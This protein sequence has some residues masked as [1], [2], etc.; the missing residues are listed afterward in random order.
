[1]IDA[2]FPSAPPTP[3]VALQLGPLLDDSASR[4]IGA[5]LMLLAC[6]VIGMLLLRW[7]RPVSWRFRFYLCAIILAQGVLLIRLPVDL[8]ILPGSFH[9]PGAANLS[10]D[11]SSRDAS[12]QWPFTSDGAHAARSID[13]PSR[14]ENSRRESFDQTQTGTG[15][16]GME[17]FGANPMPN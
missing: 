2:A 11:F 8:P 7:L 4:F 13:Q 1:M 3:P 17:P 9:D 16:N 15:Q 10:A 14:Q 5:S 6:G 12:A